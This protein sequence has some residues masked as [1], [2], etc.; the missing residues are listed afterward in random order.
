MRTDGKFMIN[1]DIPEGQGSVAALL[2]EC[3]DLAYDLRTQAEESDNDDDDD[4]ADKDGDADAGDREH[5]SRGHKDLDGDD[6]D[7]DEDQTTKMQ[8]V[9][10]NH[11]IIAS[12]GETKGMAA[13]SLGAE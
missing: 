6:D 13:L 5:R 12:A 2:A 1:G 11:Q 10:A 3:F 8:K 7:G 4:D 9:L